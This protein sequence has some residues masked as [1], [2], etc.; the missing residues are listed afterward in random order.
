MG[1]TMWPVMVQRMTEPGVDVAVTV[2][3]NPVVGPVLTVGPGGA[4]TDLA[5]AHAHILPLTDR[6]ADRFVGGLPLAGL[7]GP[8][9]RRNVDDLLARVGALVEAV[10]EITGLELNPVI[11][12]PDR[13]VVV[14]ARLWAAPVDRDPLPPV[15]RL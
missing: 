9:G 7:L 8:E 14:D 5:T 11:V 12:T 1:D 10:P 15:R 2:A 6:Q 13:A 3:L 4:A